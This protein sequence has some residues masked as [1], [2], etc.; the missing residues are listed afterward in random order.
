MSCPFSNTLDQSL[1]SSWVEKPVF[2]DL[3]IED[4][5]SDIVHREFELHNHEIGQYADIFK[6]NMIYNGKLLKKLNPNLVG[7]LELPLLLE[8]RIMDIIQKETNALRQ[9]SSHT[10]SGDLNRISS[11][12]KEAI[13]AQR[14]ALLGLTPEMKVSLKECWNKLTVGKAGK[15]AE[16]FDSFYSMFLEKDAVG[17]QLFQGA[18]MANQAQSLMKMLKFILASIDNP[19]NL[20]VPLQKL[21]IRHLIYGVEK[22][23]FSSFGVALASTFE[24]VLGKEEVTPEMKEAWYVL[25]M[26]LGEVMMAEYPHARKGWRGTVSIRT[27]SSRNSQWKVRSTLLNHERL[28][29]YRN[30]DYSKKVEEIYLKLIEDI[31]IVE[32]E[33]G[34]EYITLS[35]GATTFHLKPTK[36]E[37][38][39]WVD[40]LTVR[41]RAHQ[42]V[43]TIDDSEHSDESRKSSPVPSRVKNIHEQKIKKL[44]QGLQRKGKA[45]VA[46]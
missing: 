27:R 35:T 24:K 31:D 45:S 41:I 44:K 34:E 11:D 7:K 18:S 8:S 6:A 20:L 39:K 2:D 32:E 33:N 28:V 3:P 42:R 4:I 36:D 43:N 23:S 37:F 17:K 9:Y 5:L 40:D 15:L 25:T 19:L 10:S 16:F 30:D 38:D 1:E 14:S 26:K 12:R 22:S 46:Q 29:I 13:Q 21:G